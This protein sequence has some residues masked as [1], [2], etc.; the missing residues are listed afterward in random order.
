M[1]FQNGCALKLKNQLCFPL[2]AAS[3]EIIKMYKPYLD[4]LDLTYTQ[5]IAIL[6]LWEHKSMTVKEI[7]EHLFLD[8]GTLTPLL[9]K[10]EAKGYITRARSTKDERNLNVSLTD[11]GR[12]LQSK[13]KGIPLELG[14]YNPLSLEETVTLYRLLYKLLGRE[15]SSQPDWAFLECDKDCPVSCFKKDGSEEA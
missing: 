8:S 1:D 6:L 15:G 3:R 12:A 4:E 5:Y 14:K 7:G 9:K 10:L 2:Y 13:A 11:E